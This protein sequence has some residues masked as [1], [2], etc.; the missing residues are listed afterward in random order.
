MALSYDATKI[1]NVRVSLEGTV[2]EDW[3]WN[4]KELY[5]WVTQEHVT[6]LAM[7]DAWHNG[8]TIPPGSGPLFKVQFNINESAPLGETNLVLFN[9]PESP[10][11]MSIYI[12]P[13][14][15]YDVIPQLFNGTVNIQWICGDVNAD[16]VINVG[17]I[18]YLTT[19][20][21]RGGP[22]PIP[23]PCYGDVNCDDIVNVGDV[24]YLITYLYRGGSSPCPECCNPPWI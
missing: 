23:L 11:L 1:E 14:G 13:D 3:G 2:A 6:F 21:Y 8:P 4:G 7:Y 18:V 20:L 5:E 17:D 9:A 15:S 22:P 19:Y 12:P 16:G 24:V 10:P